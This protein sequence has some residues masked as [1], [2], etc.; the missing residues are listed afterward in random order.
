MATK[1]PRGPVYLS[2]AGVAERYGVHA[3]TVWRWAKAGQIPQPVKLGPR[4]TRWDVRELEQLDGKRR[5]AK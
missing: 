5:A 3:N 1:E 2:A 4:A